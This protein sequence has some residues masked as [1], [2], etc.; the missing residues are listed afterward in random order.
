MLE[1]VIK[2]SYYLRKHLEAPL[3][4]ERQE[5]LQY[6]ASKG[7]YRETLMAFLENL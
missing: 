3:L 6:L 2:R 4:K 1:Q 5:Y 7:Y